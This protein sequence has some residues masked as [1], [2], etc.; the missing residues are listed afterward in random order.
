MTYKAFWFVAILV[1]LLTSACGS[2]A[3]PTPGGP[4]PVGAYTAKS[5]PDIKLLFTQGGSYTF[6]INGEVKGTYVISGN[7]IT[8][9][10]TVGGTAQCVGIPGT[11][12]WSFDGST[13]TFQLVQDDCAPRKNDWTNAW[14][15]QP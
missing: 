7:Q 1:V 15:K 12:T 9:T 8:F 11:Y 13:L 5:N 3:A 14:V 2:A 6:G 10:E 4:F